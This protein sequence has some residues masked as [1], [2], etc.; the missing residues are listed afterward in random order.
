MQ[1][2][3]RRVKAGFLSISSRS[4]TGLAWSRSMDLKIR[5]AAIVAAH[6]PAPV[7]G[8]PTWASRPGRLRAEWL[9]GIIYKN[10]RFL[11][12]DDVGVGVE[13]LLEQRGPG[14]G[15]A[16]EERQAA[17]RLELSSEVVPAPEGLGGEPCL[18]LA[19]DGCAAFWRRVE[20]RR[21]VRAQA[22]PWLPET[23]P[24]LR[25]NGRDDRAPCPIHSSRQLAC[26]A[27]RWPGK[28]AG[29]VPRPPTGRPGDPV[30]RA[31]AAP[32]RIGLSKCSARS[33]SARASSTRAR[34]S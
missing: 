24:W 10:L 31:P 7:Q 21:R 26:G 11:S 12:R 5:R 18:P 2:G 30:A 22:A 34:C 33:T 29:S 4:A 25:H 20:E 32:A 6:R 16:A 14:P 17:G 23:P 27:R 15:M 28:I 8:S 13:H 9:E 1:A 19:Y 3:M